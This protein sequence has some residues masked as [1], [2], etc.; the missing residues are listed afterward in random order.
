[1]SEHTLLIASVE[2]L[3]SKLEKRIDILEKKINAEF[4]G[5]SGYTRGC[6]CEICSEAKMNYIKEYRKRKK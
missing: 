6:R 5:H 2:K 4:H 1:M 3:F